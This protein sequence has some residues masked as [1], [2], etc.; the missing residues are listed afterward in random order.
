MRG[1]AVLTALIIGASGLATTACGQRQPAAH[2]AGR[3]PATACAAGS[4]PPSTT[5][6]ISNADNG[7]VRCITVGAHVL[8]YLSGTLARK[9]API[10]ADQGVLRPEAN[11]RLALKIGVTGA[12]YAAVRPGTT[13]LT[14]TQSICQQAGSD[15]CGAPNDF[16]V[17]V[18]VSRSSHE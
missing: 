3:P 5:L 17:T 8:V 10:H 9:W 6:T 4:S 1:A 15:G 7:Q 14:S 12:F 16:H 11:G 18:I 2:A 13:R